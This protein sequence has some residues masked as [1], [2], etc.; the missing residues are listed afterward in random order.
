[1][2]DIKI[3]DF[4]A[5]MAKKIAEEAS[6]RLQKEQEALNEYYFKEDLNYTLNIIKESAEKNEECIIF[7]PFNKDI[8]I[9][10]RI[11]NE[12]QKRGFNIIIENYHYKISW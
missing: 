4:D 1:M 5:S 9:N 11:I 7:H 10:E 3:I 8:E 12:L 2:E 6:I